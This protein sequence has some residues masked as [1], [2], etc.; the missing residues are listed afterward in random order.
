MLK[1]FYVFALQALLK[2][3]YNILKLAE[4]IVGTLTDVELPQWKRRQQMACLG[5]PADVCLD[6]LQKW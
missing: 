2:Q 5:S 3:M 1:H 4:E 6:H